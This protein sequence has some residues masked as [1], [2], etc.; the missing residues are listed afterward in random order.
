L[1]Q[2]DRIGEL[3]VDSA[4]RSFVEEEALP[5][6]SIAPEAFW[7]GFQALIAQLTPENKRLLGRREE[8][9]AL[10]DARN[11]RLDGRAPE[12]AEEESFLREIGYLVE[13]PAP[14]TIGTQNVDPEIADIAGP[15]LVVP[16]NNARY[17]L[18][19]VNARWGSLY[20]ALYGTDALGDLACPGGYDPERGA[21]VIAW[22]RRFL[23]EIAPLTGG[24]HAD[25]GEYRVE[26]GQL[27]TDCGGLADGSLFAGHRD[28]SILIRHNKLHVE[29][30]ID[31]AQPIGREDKAGV[32]DIRL[33][34]AITAIM[35]C[36]D[37]VAV[38]QHPTAAR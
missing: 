29:L 28:G 36:E 5:G 2:Y 35:D 7:S 24:S 23:D 13:P 32:A 15:Q 12:P 18:N 37:S 6:T 1:P 21:R 38:F 30:V 17:A 25:V 22:G 33:E 26:D 16:V 11:E 19:A 20:D 3:E 9:Q 4:L 10:I 31:R 8:L 34:A 27:R 14:F